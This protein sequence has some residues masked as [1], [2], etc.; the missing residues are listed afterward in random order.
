M[1]EGRLPSQLAATSSTCSSQNARQ[2]ASAISPRKDTPPARQ[3]AAPASSRSPASCRDQ[4]TH[5]HDGIPKMREGDP[6]PS[7]WPSSS[8]F[9]HLFPLLYPARQECAHRHGAG[10]WQTPPCR[11]PPGESLE[12]T[13]LHSSKRT[14]YPS[15]RAGSLTGGSFHRTAGERSP[16]FG[17]LQP[18]S[19][20]SSRQRAPPP[21][22]R[23]VSPAPGA[24]GRY[25]HLPHFGHLYSR[26]AALRASGD[27]DA[28]SLTC[29]TVLRRSGIFSPQ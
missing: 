2:F 26:F 3:A 10:G 27:T 16:R 13:G 20:P 28:G 24:P 25:G 29:S 1:S 11:T 8:S 18:A 5:R 4:Y 14:K 15:L 19:A 6:L 17:A 12:A 23:L 21:A 7:G 22:P 9:I